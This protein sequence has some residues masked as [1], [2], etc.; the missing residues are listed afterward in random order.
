MLL[1]KTFLRA[2]QGVKNAR[3]KKILARTLSAVNM[4]LK[5]H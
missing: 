3:L 4:I 1:K 2:M 5:S